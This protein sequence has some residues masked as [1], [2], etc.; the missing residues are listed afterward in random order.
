MV[1]FLTGRAYDHSITRV[2]NRSREINHVFGID[3]PALTEGLDEARIL[4][5]LPSLKEKVSGPNGIY[6]SRCFGDLV[7][8]IKHPDDTAFYCYRGIESLRHHCASSHQLTD[9]SKTVQWAKFREMAGV[10]QDK[11]MAIKT[12]ADGLRHGDPVR[13]FNHDRTEVMREAWGIVRQ[14]IAA[15]RVTNG[16]SHSSP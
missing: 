11:I 4:D 3:V 16:E 8:A 1:G 12:A 13:A 2:L 9:E 10:E 14:Y 7:A 15:I 6:L 5:E